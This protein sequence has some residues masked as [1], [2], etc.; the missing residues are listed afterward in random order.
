MYQLSSKQGRQLSAEENDDISKRLAT[1]PLT[2]TSYLALENIASCLQTTCRSLQ[3]PMEQWMN[4]I[5]NERTDAVDRSYYYYL[6]G[7][8]LSGQGRIHEAI[9][10]FRLS[11]ESDQQYLHPLLVLVKIFIQLRQLEVAEYVLTELHKANEKSLHPRGREIKE[12][13]A[14]L[15]RNKQDTSDTSGANRL[16]VTR[17]VP[18][19]NHQKL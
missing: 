8:S 2:P 15:Q 18:S 16:P 10:V 6:L 3:V 12:L 13:D 9:D 17:L 7:I 11:Y 5:L 19:A 14:E 1:A 4:I